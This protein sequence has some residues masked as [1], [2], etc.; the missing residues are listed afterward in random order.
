MRMSA[1]MTRVEARVQVTHGLDL[2]AFIVQRFKTDPSLTVSALAVEL[3]VDKVTL[4]RWL[5]K[6]ELEL[7][8]GP[9]LIDIR[10]ERQKRALAEADATVAEL[11]GR[12]GS[13]G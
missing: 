10:A 3:D 1:Q 9:R 2:R 5:D 12:T 4:Y 13:D 7:A 6:L 11:E 8:D